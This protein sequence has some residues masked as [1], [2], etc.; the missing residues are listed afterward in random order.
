MDW[1][2]TD[3]TASGDADFLIMGDLNSYAMEDTLTNLQ[4]GGYTNLLK[5]FHGNNTYSYLFG[6]QFGY[7]D[8]AVANE[9]LFAQ[10]TGIADWKINA[11][12][13]DALDYNTDFKSP[14]QITNLYAADEFRS[15]DHD[16][17]IVG[18]KLTAPIIPIYLPLITR[19]A[20]LNTPSDTLTTWTDSVSSP[21][22]SLEMWFLQAQAWLSS[23]ATKALSL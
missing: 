2:K 18:L 19:E 11:D 20:F 3:P 6:G 4:A 1:L 9:S 8:H 16:P 12:E 22:L 13:A 17:L 5:A 21:A 15:S 23:L 7:L 10:V 14:S